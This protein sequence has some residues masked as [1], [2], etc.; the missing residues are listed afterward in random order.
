MSNKR[1]STPKG[2]PPGPLPETWFTMTSEEKYHYFMDG[3][4][5]S[6]GKPFVSTEVAAKYD[7]RAKRWR[8]I[9]ELR[10]PDRVPIRFH[11][12]GFTLENAGGKPVDEF[13]NPEKMV[14]GSC[15]FH[16]DYPLEYLSV[17][18]PMSGRALDLLGYNV[19]RW[20]G[21]PLPTGLADE[22][23]HQYVEKD[24]M[25]ADDYESM[26]A[27]PDGYLLR[28]YLPR[29]STGLKGLE[30]LPSPYL[31]TSAL[32]T[33]PFLLKLAQGPLREAFDTLLKAADQAKA[34]ADKVMK[35]G[36]DIIWRFGTPSLRGSFTLT[37]FDLIGNTMRGTVEIMLDM[38]R[39]P[40]ALAAAC[41][42]LLPV[43]VNIA[44]ETAKITRNPFVFIP[45][46]K[47]ADGFMSDEQFQKF[48]WPTL[49][50]LLL[51]LIDAGLVPFPFA[52][53]NY[54]KRLDIIAEAR[55]P[56]GKTVWVFDKT[57]M[58]AAKEK[59]GKFA[60]I[61]GNVPAS[62][63]FVGT[64]QM[65]EDYCKDLLDVSAPGGGFFLSPGA[66][67]DHAKPENVRAFLGIRRKYAN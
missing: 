23:P 7:R 52:E 19:I 39:R 59:F 20:P 35:A 54:T 3:W 15:Q 4:A 17:G 18:A 64:P 51:A 26:I 49:H 67:I 24:F 41:E 21:S 58:K 55:L 48:Y 36:L 9:V 56:V 40:D 66:A 44:V 31:F 25:L 6:E 32:G 46:H 38:Y 53:G 12:A 27:N 11:G 42:A 14:S 16:E 5:S 10:E 45:L 8:D 1:S 47:G 62:L 29:I 30:N 33:L 43:V 63:F 28:E 50:D 22:V 2:M 61:G 13:Y 60:C 34:D 37:P 57:D 65:I